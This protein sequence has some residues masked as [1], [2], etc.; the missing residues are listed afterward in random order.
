MNDAYQYECATESLEGL[1]RRL[2][3]LTARNRLLNFTH[4]RQGNVRIIDELPDELH[5]MLLSEEELRFQTIPDPTRE[6]LIREGYIQIDPETGL[7]VRA[8]KDP[9]AAEWA[10]LLGYATD[11]ELPVAVGDGSDAAKHLDKKIQTLMFPSEMETRLRALRNKAETAIEETGANICYVAFGFLEW[12]EGPDSQK[13]RQAPLL[14][15]PVRIAK[16]RLNRET[17]TYDYTTSYT[18][19]DILP[20]LSLR[21]MLRVNFALALPDLDDATPPEAYFA[22]VAQ[23]IAQPQPRWQVRRYASVALFNFSKL[24]MYLDLDA[25][26]WPS[27]RPIL[28]HPIVSRFFASAKKDVERHWLW[29]RAPHR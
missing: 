10:R 16:G 27:D 22:E 13:P 29:R 7:D 28:G 25:E 11:F 2:L 15:V 23:L 4:G 14:L 24:L 18:G 9:T 6:Q 12:L 1:R 20:N 19:E 3:D 8:K 17:G 21:E 26:R 5:R